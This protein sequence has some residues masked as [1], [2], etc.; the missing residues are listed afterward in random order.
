MNIVIFRCKYCPC[1]DPVFDIDT[2]LM[3][4]N[5]PKG[6]QVIGGEMLNGQ[7]NLLLNKTT[8]FCLTV[9]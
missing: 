5:M 3:H 1:A 8:F 7:F 9:K 4:F 6:R 2:I